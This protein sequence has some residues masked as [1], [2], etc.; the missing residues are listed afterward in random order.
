MKSL[1]CLHN[2][3]NEKYVLYYS[4]LLV[5][6]LTVIIPIN[7]QFMKLSFA[8]TAILFAIGFL[9]LFMIARN[10]KAGFGLLKSLRIERGSNLLSQKIQHPHFNSTD[11]YQD[12]I[13]L[14]QN[15][16]DELSR[17]RHEKIDWTTLDS[18]HML[19]ARLLQLVEAK[20]INV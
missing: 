19:N 12:P 7:L 14:M 9:S 1:S 3:Q 5:F 20:V 16:V 15:F 2:S 10:D 8:A 17:R 11:S 4:A 13:V 6:A 18:F